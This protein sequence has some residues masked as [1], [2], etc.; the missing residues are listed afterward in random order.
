MIA[1]HRA[2]HPVDCNLTIFHCLKN[3][4][5]IDEL[6]LAYLDRALE[7]REVWAAPSGLIA[8]EATDELQFEP[9]R[10]LVLLG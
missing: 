7:E 2:G 10:L 6:F 5:P 3:D 8:G 4:V 1:C 9:D